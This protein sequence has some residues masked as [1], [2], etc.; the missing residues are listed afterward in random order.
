MRGLL[1]AAMTAAFVGPLA[2]QD[3]HV[4]IVTG[5]SGEPRFATT[6]HAAAAVLY[7]AA[8]RWGVADSSRIY[9]AEDP[10]LDPAR[11]RGRATREA[12][13]AELLALSS[14]VAPGDVVFLFL[15]GHGA[16]FGTNSRIS[17][18]GPDATAADFVT[19]LAGFTQQTLII[20]NAGSAS[21]DFVE[22]LA[23]P[24]RIVVT[25]T[26]SATERNETVFA[27]PF[28]RGLAG[29]AGDA[30]KD[31]R[32]SLAEAFAYA[33]NEV[34]RSY[35]VGNRLQTEHA[36]LSDS[37][38]ASV[39]AFGAPPTAADPQVAALLRQRRALEGQVAG[40]R[41]RKSTMNATDYDRE[42]E[43]LLLE[44]AIKTQAIRA[45]RESP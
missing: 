27:E 12:L 26:R 39:V 24:G 38:F 43:R 23:T 8:G 3:I 9:L 16:G 36:R 2:G 7:D 35:Q 31:G 22:A 33:R 40:L 15:L 32:T 30:D 10:A 14:R 20:V 25:A 1:L 45:A 4:L 41:A 29:E 5:L 11:I 19:W 13:A 37:V 18:P 17:L 44:I 6:Y 21:G 34:A 28:V 42:L